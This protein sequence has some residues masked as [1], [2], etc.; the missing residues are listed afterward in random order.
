MDALTHIKKRF[1]LPEKFKSPYEVSVT[2]EQ[3]YDVFA[4]LGFTKGVEVGV[5]RGWN[6]KVMCDRI[7]NLKLFAVDFWKGY[8]AK[9]TQK[10][11]DRYLR[12]AKRHLRNHIKNKSVKLIRKASMA[13]VKDFEDESLDFVYID[14]NHNFDV[15]MEDIIEWSKKL[16]PGGIMSGHDY[17]RRERE[18]GV[19]LAVNTYVRAHRIKPWFLTSE[20]RKRSF[21]WIK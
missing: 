2:R 8:S 7:P 19:I 9:R 14:S 11:Q 4:E 21:F 20:K 12:Q 16:R 6:A 5:Y 1:D 10:K 15:V 3:L 17:Y 13:A 18:R